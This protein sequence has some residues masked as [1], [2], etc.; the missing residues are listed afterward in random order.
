MVAVSR[1]HDRNRAGTGILVVEYTTNGPGSAERLERRQSQP[2]RLVFREHA[3]DAKLPSD[4]A[5]DER[6]HPVPSESP[7]KCQRRRVRTATPPTPRHVGWQT[8]LGSGSWGRTVDLWSAP[9]FNCR[10]DP[11]SHVLQGSHAI[12]PLE[13]PSSLVPHAERRRARCSPHPKRCDDDLRCVVCSALA[14]TAASAKRRRSSA[15][16]TSSTITMTRVPPAASNT[17]LQ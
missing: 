6:S 1:R 12:H 11:R 7:M 17:G 13:H 15:A 10:D 9:T 4:E 5:T 2:S 14:F 8:T 3:P 16:G